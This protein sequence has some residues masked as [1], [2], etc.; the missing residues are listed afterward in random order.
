[1]SHFVASEEPRNPLNSAQIALFD[2]T[3]AVFPGIPPSLC[4]SSALFLPQ[5]P[6]Y[7]LVRP[8][9]AL[10]GGNPTP[11]L[12]NPMRPVVSLNVAIQQTRWI[13]AGQTVG[14]NAQWTAPRRTRLA[15][16]LAGYADGLPR[17]AGA[18]NDFAG[19]DVMIAGRRCRLVGRMSMDLCVADVTEMPEEDARPG[20]HAQF[21]GDEIGVDELGQRSRTIGYHILTSLGSRYRRTYRGA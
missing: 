7:D 19:A 16:L 5:P 1:M 2:T 9:Y 18:T 20:V 6:Y 8:G 21:L 15:T 10:Y 17:T 13:E 4:N 12:P 14:Y 3:R 11:G